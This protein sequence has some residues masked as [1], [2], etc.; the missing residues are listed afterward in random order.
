MWPFSC[1]P[2]KRSNICPKIRLLPGQL[3]HQ[4]LGGGRRQGSW[5]P[6]RLPGAGQKFTPAFGRRKELRPRAPAHPGWA[7]GTRPPSAPTEGWLLGCGTGLGADRGLRQR[8]CA[9][10]SGLALKGGCKGLS[11]LLLLLVAQLPQ[12]ATSE[13]PP[14][15]AGTPPGLAH[16]RC[17]SGFS[18]PSVPAP[19]PALLPSAGHRGRKKKEVE[20]QLGSILSLPLPGEVERI[21]AE[22]QRRFYPP[23]DPGA[24][25]PNAVPLSSHPHSGPYPLLSCH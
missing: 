24:S 12:E 2:L 3:C 5:G 18:T 15:P 16:L 11:T 23:G 10:G 4:R 9:P 22:I 7:P 8:V 21:S 14:E 19:C 13:V 1:P 17:P 6:G 20:S 25:F